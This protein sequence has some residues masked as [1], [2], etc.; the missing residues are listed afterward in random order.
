MKFLADESCDHLFVRKLRHDKQDIVSIA[1]DFA[2]LDDESV[3]ELALKED[4]ILLSEDR[5]FGH[6]VFAQSHR[7]VGVILLRYPFSSREHIWS[8]LRELVNDEGDRLKG[9]FIVIQPGKNRI[10]ELP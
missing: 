4:R 10:R 9:K 5:D 6:Y 3:A 1:E 8:Q 7:Q 2:G